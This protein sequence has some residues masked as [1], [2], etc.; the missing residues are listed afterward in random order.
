MTVEDI[1]A[2]LSQA[3]QHGMPVTIRASVA[4][5]GAES[6][7]IDTSALTSLR[8]NSG[9][10]V[11]SAGAGVEV[12]T[13]ISEVD[14]AG[15][16]VLGMPKNPNAKHVGSLIATGEIS[17][18]GLCGIRALLTTGEEVRAGGEVQKDVTGYDL[19]GY[20]LGSMGRAGVITEANFR[21]CPRGVELP[22]GPGRGEAAVTVGPNLSPAFD[23]DGVLTRG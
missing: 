3:A 4:H 16:R 1:V 20:F 8:L 5:A 2:Q 10:A 23:P 17:R 18:R 9:A 11:V 19:C 7:V 12:S 14:R 13:L 6:A 21:L 15:Y 22:V